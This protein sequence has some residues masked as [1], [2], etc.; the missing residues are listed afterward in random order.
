MCSEA[1]WWRRH[2]RIIA[3]YPLARGE[4][5]FPILGPGRVEQ[6]RLTPEAVIPSD[7]AIV[8]PAA[9]TL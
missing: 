4:A 1:V 2:R 3:D 6:A 8:Y 5:V 9:S 7:G